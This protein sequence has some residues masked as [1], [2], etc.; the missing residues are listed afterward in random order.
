LRIIHSF[1]Q[2][3]AVEFLICLLWSV[4]ATFFLHIRAILLLQSGECRAV[5][6]TETAV[7]HEK[8]IIPGKCLRRLDF[9]EQPFASQTDL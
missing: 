1:C 6:E 3:A 9:A 8:W 2:F 5:K 7:F 4:F